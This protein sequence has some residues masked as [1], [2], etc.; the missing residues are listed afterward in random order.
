MNYNERLLEDDNPVHAGFWYLADGKPVQLWE[1]GTVA[2]LRRR[3]PRVKEWRY[4]DLSKR[5]L[6]PI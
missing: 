3:S 2:D 6:K 4:A 5:N 1:G